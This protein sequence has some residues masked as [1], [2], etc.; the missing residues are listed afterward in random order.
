MHCHRFLPFSVHHSYFLLAKNPPH[1]SKAFP[2]K[3]MRPGRF[4]TGF[5]GGEYD[6]P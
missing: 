1:N 2:A 5:L 3:S 4:L 6:A